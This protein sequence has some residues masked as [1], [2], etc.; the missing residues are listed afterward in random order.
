MTTSSE[1]LTLPR[2]EISEAG[3]LPTR[4]TARPGRTPAAERVLTSAATSA[5][6]SLA[7][8]LPSRSVAA[9]APRN[10]R[11]RR[12]NSILKVANFAEPLTDLPGWIVAQFAPLA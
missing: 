2:P 10:Q 9:M 4:I 5:R 11:V 8:L 3:L 1:L 7:I 12:K 6:I